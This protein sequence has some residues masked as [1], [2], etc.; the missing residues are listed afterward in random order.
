MRWGVK[1]HPRLHEEMLG[2]HATTKRIKDLERGIEYEF[3]IAGTNHIGI[4]QESVKYYTT[5]EGTPTG[6][7]TNITHR[8]QTPDVI[9]ITW[10]LPLREHRNGQILRYDI[11][12]HKKID[13]GL[14]TERNITTRKAV[15]ANLDQ[16]TEYVIRIR[17][18]TKQGK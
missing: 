13:H 15:F 6:P 10:D 17:A 5:P 18:Y 2:P 4:G 3:R 11:Q 8:F 7:P 16:N 12:F 9:A 1:D 14:G